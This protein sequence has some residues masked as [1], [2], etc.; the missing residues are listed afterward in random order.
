[1]VQ[2]RAKSPNITKKRKAA[3]E[4]QPG[5]K[6]RAPG[7]AAAAGDDVTHM[8]GDDISAD[9]SDDEGDDASSDT[10]PLPS[11][12]AARQR[13]S[14]YSR[15]DADRLEKLEDTVLELQAEVADLTQQVRTLLPPT[16]HTH[17]WLYQDFKDSASLLSSW[18]RRCWCCRSRSQA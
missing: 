11:A 15:A 6:R 3:A 9:A 8:D 10:F 12:A 5:A 4:A 2:S 1:M 17:K 18:Q 16:V 13:G 14:S 7:G